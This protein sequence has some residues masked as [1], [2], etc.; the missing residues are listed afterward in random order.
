MPTGR[1]GGEVEQDADGMSCRD[2][3]GKKGHGR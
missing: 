2:M 1:E 3:L